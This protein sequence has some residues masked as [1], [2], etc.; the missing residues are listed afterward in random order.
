MYPLN[1]DRPWPRNQW[2]VAGFS[3]EV[4]RDLIGRTLLGSRL[5]LFRD[6]AGTAHALSGVCPHRMMP[7]EQGSLEGDR[8]VCGYHGLTFDTQ[9]AC[10]DAPSSMAKPT[11]ALTRY[12]LKEVWPFL[13]IWP[14]DPA[15]AEQTPLPPQNS[16]GVN[17]DGWRTDPVHHFELAARYPLLIDNLFDLS[18]LG[19]IHASIV[20]SGGIALAE[21]HIAEREGRLVVARELLDV[22]VDGYHRFLYPDIGERMS[23]RLE[24]DMVGIGLINAGGPVWEGSDREAG[25]TGR[26]NFVHAFTP[27]TETRTHYWILTARN[28]RPSDE[29]LSGALAAQMKAVA[30]Q[31]V[32]ALEAIERLLAAP[33]DLPRETSMKSDN[34]ALRARLRVIQMIRAESGRAPA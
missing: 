3:S 1:T 28:F 22:P 4:G 18:H 20:G 6:E 10:V 32:V 8:L 30:Q 33:G 23:V 12:P 7:M 11:C 5:V 15:L 27:E 9:G 14:G 17:A 21:P 29:A 31:D 25:E 19:F 2:F 13:W 34:G 26:M 24:S 16:I